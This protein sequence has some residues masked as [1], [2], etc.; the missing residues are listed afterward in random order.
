[1]EMAAALRARMLEL[2]FRFNPTPQ[3]AITHT[4]PRLIAGEPLHPAIR[5]YLHDADIYAC[6]P[7]VLA[8]Q[9]Q[10]T[11]RTGDRFFFTT[12]KRQPSQKSGKSSRAV[13]A[14]GPGSWHSQGNTTD[15]KDGT[16]VKIGEVKKLR[17]KKGGKFT[18]WL[19]DEFCCC[20]KDAVVGDTQQRVL[21]K[22]YV[23]PRA[24]PDSVARQED[25]AAAA[26]FAPPASFEEPAA[27]PKRPAPPIDEPPCPK[28]PR[29]EVASLSTP[30][31]IGS[32]ASTL[33]PTRPVQP[34]TVAQAA[35]S[36]VAACDPFCTETPATAEDDGDFV[37][38][39]EGTLDT[40]Q[41]EEDHAR[42]DTDWFA[43]AMARDAKLTMA[44]PDSAARQE[45]AAAAFAPPVPEEVVVAPKRPAPP[46]V[47]QPCPKRPR[48]A[49]APSS[50]PSATRSPASTLAPALAPS[51]PVQAST[52][53][54]A[55]CSPVAARD[56]FCAESPAVAQD[57]DDD[58]VSFLE[59][60]LETE[61]AE[62]DKAQ[63][64][65]DWCAAAMARDAK[66]TMC[67]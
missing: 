35:C 20:S 40:E 52:M 7:G 41:A 5:P 25:A 14:A 26:A 42:D 31:A 45:S 66:L 29:Q 49:V 19:M 43:A 11:P 6:E 67:A 21:C 39:L 62:E 50:A 38:F 18:D 37:S 55:A 4:L 3:E 36:P 32:P 57:D 64:D 9:F 28:R 56:P 44:A 17:Y 27:A 8:A 13:R 60:N 51:R 23:S 58:F 16:G 54:Q 2:D 12:C 59:G 22:I 15:V 34:T 65:T 61:Q 24:A 63:D 1:M 33:A 48:C 46:V 30:S 10:P 53:V 47:E